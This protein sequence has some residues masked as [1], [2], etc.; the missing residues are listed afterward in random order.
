[1]SVDRLVAIR[2]PIYHRI[3]NSCN[4]A[5]L[6]IIIIWIISLIPTLIMNISKNIEWHLEVHTMTFGPTFY[7][8]IDEDYNPLPLQSKVFGI[9]YCVVYWVFPWILTTFLTI[10]VGF[11]GWKSLK[12]I[13]TVPKQRIK[14]KIS[15]T[16]SN[17]TYQTENS[18]AKIVQVSMHEDSTDASNIS[19]DSQTHIIQTN[20][21]NHRQSKKIRRTENKNED[22]SKRLVKTLTILVIMYTICTL[23]LTI[24]QLYMWINDGKS[25]GGDSFR[26]LWFL[27]SFL[28]LA[29]SA[30]NIFIYHRSKE[31]SEAL[32]SLYGY[33]KSSLIYSSGSYRN[34]LRTNITSKVRL[35]KQQTM[36]TSDGGNRI[37]TIT[38]QPHLVNN[39]LGVSSSPATA[40]AAAGMGNMNPNLHANA[41]SRIYIDRGHVISKLDN[42]QLNNLSSLNQQRIQQNADRLAV[43]NLDIDNDSTEY[44]SPPPKNEEQI[45]SFDGKININNLRPLTP[46]QSEINQMSQMNLGLNNE[47]FDND[48][49]SVCSSTN[50]SSGHN[51]R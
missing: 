37:S 50:S 23:P 45:I 49:E 27:A 10:G 29:Q 17:N 6:S 31:F 42:D 7:S 41:D 30:M 5:I 2:W 26:W 25:I 38:G 36:T 13:K 14:N 18:Q 24:L 1:M 43:F 32:K 3:H 11:Y 48:N 8:E 4:R 44:V 46:I 22:S 20:N 40:A 34:T 51:N 35:F 28:Y 33:K 19:G 39:G 12:S 9:S 47:T 15:D 21:N 16:P